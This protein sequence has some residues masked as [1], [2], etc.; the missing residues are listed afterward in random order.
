MRENNPM[1][2]RETAER[3]GRI[4]LVD[5]D[6]H[7]SLPAD[8]LREADVVAVAVRQHHRPHVVQ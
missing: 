5:A 4:E 1:G 3:Q 2:R 7:A 8:A 6:A